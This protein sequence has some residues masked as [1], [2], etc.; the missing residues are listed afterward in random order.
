M[1]R[2]AILKLSFICISSEKRHILQQQEKLLL[3]LLE[4]KII[5]PLL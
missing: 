4:I 2:N 3:K 5:F 1:Q